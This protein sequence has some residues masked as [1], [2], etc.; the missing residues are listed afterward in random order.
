MVS[1]LK[2]LIAFT[3]ISFLVVLIFPF[4]AVYALI[5]AVYLDKR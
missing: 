3:V 1:S 5:E 4:L 2:Q